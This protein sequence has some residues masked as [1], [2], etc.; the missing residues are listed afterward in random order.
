MFIC[1]ENT[2]AYDG[3]LVLPVAP[4]C[5]PWRGNEI[6]I[7]LATSAAIVCS[8]HRPCCHCLLGNESKKLDMQLHFLREKKKKKYDRYDPLVVRYSCGHKVR[9]LS[10]RKPLLST[11]DRRCL[12]THDRHQTRF[13]LLI[14]V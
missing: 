8:I 4:S 10:P 9:Y 14:S 3:G 12:S 11:R 6:Q 5:V 1:L 13:I 7:Q 2:R